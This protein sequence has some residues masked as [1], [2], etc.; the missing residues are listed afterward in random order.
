MVKEFIKND[1]LNY[2]MFLKF[3]P[4]CGL[5][6]GESFGALPESGAVVES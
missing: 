1:F 5:I 2:K 3:Y 6:V 4:V